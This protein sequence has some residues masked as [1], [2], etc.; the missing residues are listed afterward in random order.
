MVVVLTFALTTELFA[1]NSP[2][3]LYSQAVDKIRASDAVCPPS[4]SSYILTDEL[5][6]RSLINTYYPHSN[7]HI[8]HI[9]QLPS[10]VHHP[11]IA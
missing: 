2:S 1:T 6:F 3:V 5:P 8:P 7:S 10:E 9:L 11:Y 4:I